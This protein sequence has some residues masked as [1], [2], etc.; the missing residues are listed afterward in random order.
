MFFFPTLDR[1]KPHSLQL[2]TAPA[3]QWPTDA[4]TLFLGWSSQ[5]KWC[6]IISFALAILARFAWRSSIDLA[7]RS[8]PSTHRAISLNVAV[9]WVLL[10]IGSVA[11]LFILVERL[12]GH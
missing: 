7:Y 8:S 1:S 3:L 12:G 2:G 10:A 11:L 6:A 4:V 5:M 9:F